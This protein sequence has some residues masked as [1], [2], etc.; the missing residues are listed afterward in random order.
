MPGF[1]TKAL[2]IVL[3]MTLIDFTVSP[4]QLSD[5]QGFVNGTSGLASG[6]PD[7]VGVA[8]DVAQ[9]AFE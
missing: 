5:V 9:V 7:A 6:D 3:Y 1:I 8:I 2:T 4:N